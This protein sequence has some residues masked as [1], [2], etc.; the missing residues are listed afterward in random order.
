M[1]KS[2]TISWSSRIYT[3]YLRGSTPL[4]SKG[5]QYKLSWLKREG[6]LYVC[7]FNSTLYA[8]IKKAY[9]TTSNLVKSLLNH[10][11]IYINYINKYIPAS[12][13]QVK[14]TVVLSICNRKEDMEWWCLS[15]QET[16][17]HDE[18]DFPWNG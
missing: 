1:T 12:L 8:I 3:P 2:E 18:C 9:P 10:Y 4:K 16:S 6:L 13:L 5:L 17:M 11:I 15:S 14:C 7:M